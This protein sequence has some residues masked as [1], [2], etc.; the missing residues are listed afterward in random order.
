LIVIAYVDWPEN[1]STMHNTIFS[2]LLLAVGLTACSSGSQGKELDAVGREARS[3][4]ASLDLMYD[5]IDQDLHLV[6]FE[7]T[8][9][10]QLPTFGSI[11][12]DGVV[13]VV[14][15]QPSE[16][17]PEPVFEQAV[18]GEAHVDVVF[19]DDTLSG[20][21][22]N[23]FN[24]DNG[25]PV[26]GE[27]VFTN[28]RIDRTLEENVTT[29]TTAGE[30]SFDDGIVSVDSE[31]SGALIS[32]K[33]DYLVLRGRDPLVLDGSAATMIGIKVVAEQ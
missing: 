20:G 18:I 21:A 3:S 17:D 31:L 13:S 8:R 27:L 12:Y 15:F 10:D 25:L 19:G 24:D 30:I 32:T 1:R 22:S 7:P 14:I 11:R 2:F 4:Y 26:S 9:S 29:I 33:G 23:F 16:T 6:D 28:G 5:L